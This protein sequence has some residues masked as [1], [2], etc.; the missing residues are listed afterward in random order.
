[1]LPGDDVFDT[2]IHIAL[3][4]TYVYGDDFELGFL[5]IFGELS[6]VCFADYDAFRLGDGGR[7]RALGCAG[8]HRGGADHARAAVARCARALGSVTS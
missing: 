8:L 5:Y 7:A 2:D 3:H 4:L 6:F 1:M